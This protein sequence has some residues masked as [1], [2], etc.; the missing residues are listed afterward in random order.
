[1]KCRRCCQ[2]YFCSKE[3]ASLAWDMWH[4]KQCK[5]IGAFSVGDMVRAKGITF[6]EANSRIQKGANAVIT[7]KT[8]DGRWCVK[9]LDP[10]DDGTYEVN[11]LKSK[12]L[13]RARSLN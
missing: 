12:N 10:S 3:C 7:G 1:M 9:A 6:D 8:E 2:A 11:T 5:E 4:G 13:Y